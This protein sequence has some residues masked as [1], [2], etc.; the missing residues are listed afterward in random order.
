MGKNIFYR[1]EMLHDKGL[2][3]ENPGF[4]YLLYQCS[5]KKTLSNVLKM[6]KA[7]CLK[8]VPGS[9]CCSNES[10]LNRMIDDGMERLTDMD[11]ERHKQ[12]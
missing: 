4:K 3:I 2:E 1:G 5:L 6:M 8:T 11:K 12:T 9:L 7:C 10:F